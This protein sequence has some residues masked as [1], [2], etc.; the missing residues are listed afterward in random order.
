[1]VWSASD[2]PPFERRFRPRNPDLLLGDGSEGA[3]EAPSDDVIPRRNRPRTPSSV[4]GRRPSRRLTCV[5]ASRSASDQPPFERRLLRRNLWMARLGRRGPSPATSCG[6][7]CVLG[8]GFGRGA[9]RPSERHTVLPAER[10]YWG[11]P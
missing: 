9:K 2:Q 8:G 11:K 1:M 6:S 3:V 4:M 10:A 7:H 5:R